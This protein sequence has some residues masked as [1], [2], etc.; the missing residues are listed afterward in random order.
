MP[1]PDFLANGFLPDGVH[2]CTIDEIVDRFG[3]FVESDRRPSL[4]RELQEYLGDLRSS[5]V[6]KYLIVDGSYATSKAQPGD[7]DLL[8]VLRDEVDLN[9]TVPPF[10]FN[11]R[12]RQYVRKKYNFDFF[13]GY[14][15]DPS[16]TSILS[17]FR[18]AKHLPGVT[19]GVLRI[20]L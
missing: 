8:L 19:K 11:A 1:I 10:V 12:S 20:A 2:E 6:G 7:V 13:F 17:L 14:E 18:E 5:G 15:G 4:S 9:A 3:R 16:T